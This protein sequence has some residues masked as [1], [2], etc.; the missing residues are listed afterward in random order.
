MLRQDAFFEKHKPELDEKINKNALKRKETS[1]ERAASTNRLYGQETIA[2]ILKRNS[3]LGF[4]PAKKKPPVMP[5]RRLP[6]KKKVRKPRAPSESSEDPPEEPLPQS[7][8]GLQFPIEA[9]VPH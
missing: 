5:L 8:R 2:S 3:E 4:E 6:T 7:P 1:I 9:S